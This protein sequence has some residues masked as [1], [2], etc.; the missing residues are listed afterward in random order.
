M[1]RIAIAAVAL[2][3]FAAASAAQE[4]QLY[5]AP[6]REFVVS[7][8]GA[9]HSL[10]YIPMN[11]PFLDRAGWE[12]TLHKMTDVMGAPIEDKDVAAILDYLTRSY[13]KKG[14][15]VGPAAP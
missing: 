15:D 5:E 3:T 2:T 9:C 12:K 11:S 14:E 4:V 1:R 6:G 7:H 13:G 8:C 10:D